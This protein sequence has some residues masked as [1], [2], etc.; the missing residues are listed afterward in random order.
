MT[1]NN[2]LKSILENKKPFELVQELD[3]KYK[4]P[5][6]EEFMKT[7]ESD[8][9]VENSYKSEINVLEKGYGPC[10]S[11]YCSCSNYEL[12]QQ[13]RQTK[14]DLDNLWENFEEY[15]KAWE[16]KWENRDKKDSERRERDKI[17]RDVGNLVGL[18]PVP[19]I[20]ML[21]DNVADVVN[22]AKGGELLAVD[23]SG[24]SGGVSR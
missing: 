6:F 4:V 15:E 19:G 8:K 18:I 12:K 13:L 5:S 11:S 16:R 2:N 7:Y 1:N 21:Y 3:N 22:A 17:Q 14:E 23:I 20:S 10:A 9:T 24:F